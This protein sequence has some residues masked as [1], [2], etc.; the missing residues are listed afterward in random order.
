MALMN[1]MF[2][3]KPVILGSKLMNDKQYHNAREGL[4]RAI[5]DELDS[6]NFVVPVC[7][8]ND[9]DNSLDGI[10]IEDDNDNRRLAEREFRR[11][12]SYKLQHYIPKLNFLRS[13]VN[14][15]SKDRAI[16][17]GTGSVISEGEN[18]PSGKNLVQYLDAKGRFQV[19]RFLKD[20]ESQ[21]PNLYVVARREASRRVVEVGCERF[22]NLS[23]YVSQPRRSQLGVRN[24]ERIAMLSHL[25]N[26]VYIDPQWVAAEYLRRCK[27]GVWKKDNTVESLKCF[28]LERIL[29]A[30]ELGME[31]EVPAEITIEEYM[32]IETAGI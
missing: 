25:L 15:D 10:E 19:L 29:E 14:K 12:E 11:L 5:Q 20:H 16:E 24:Y 31:V 23:G 21:F 28:N 27:K 7:N 30:K 8:D 17:I 9:D 32:E 4:L 6:K 2:G 26:H 1:P 18:L 3:C 13:L 22:F